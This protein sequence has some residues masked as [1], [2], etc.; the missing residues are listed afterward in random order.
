[1]ILVGTIVVYLPTL[2][3]LSLLLSFSWPSDVKLNSLARFA[4]VSEAF[5]VPFWRPSLFLTLSEV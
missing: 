1:M 5:G 4:M 2:S 3:S